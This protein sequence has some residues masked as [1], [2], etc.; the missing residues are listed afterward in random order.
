MCLGRQS[1]PDSEDLHVAEKHA[2]GRRAAHS[3]YS[4]SAIFP[5]GTVVLKG[6]P[7]IRVSAPLSIL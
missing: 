3:S 2:G 6:E 5:G 7:V 1:F 4:D